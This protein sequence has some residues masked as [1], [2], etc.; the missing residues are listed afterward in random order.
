ML[1]TA[2]ELLT[3]ATVAGSVLYLVN[4]LVI[5]PARRERGPHVP[6]SALVRKKRERDAAHCTGGG[7]T[8]SRASSSSA[9]SPKPDTDMRR[10]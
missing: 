2:Q 8:R 7:A 9:A 1:W 4:K 5:A 10:P 6:A 3:A